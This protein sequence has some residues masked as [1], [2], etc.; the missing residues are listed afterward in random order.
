MGAYLKVAFLLLFQF[1]KVGLLFDV[2]MRVGLTL[3]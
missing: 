3:M 2:F 1:D